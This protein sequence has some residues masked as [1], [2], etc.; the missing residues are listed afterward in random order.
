MLLFNLN[1]LIFEIITIFEK[2]L[3]LFNNIFLNNIII[4][5]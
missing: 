4:F 5:L 3:R 2:H 1:V